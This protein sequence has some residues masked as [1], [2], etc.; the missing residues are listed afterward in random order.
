V[1]T[2][3]IMPKLGF[4]MSSGKVVRW[5]KKEGDVVAKGEPVLEIETDKATVEVQADADGL[6]GKI[7]VAEGDVP[8]GEVVG[9]IVGAGEKLSASASPVPLAKEPAVDAPAKAPQPA[10]PATAPASVAGQGAERSANMASGN[11]VHVEASPLAKRMASE[12]GIDLSAVK[13][14]GPGGRITRE[15]IEAFQATQ[16]MS[17][18][19]AVPVAAPAAPA[20]GD[21]PLSRMRQTIARRMVESKGPVPQF[22]LTTDVD[23]AAGMLVVNQLL[24]AG[25][26]EDLRPS[27][28]SLVMKACG[29]MLRKYP[30]LNASFGGDKL[31]LHDFVNISVAVAVDGGLLT[32]VVADCDRKSVAQIARD[33]R[34]AAERARS[35]KL[36]TSDL[37]QGT[38]S[39]S[40]LGMFE[41]DHFVAIVNPAEAAILALGTAKE[42]PVV[43]NGQIKSGLRMK[44]TLSADHRVTDGAE[45]ARFL[46]EVKRLLQTPMSL[47]L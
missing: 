9:E 12:M 47:F 24:E 21:K 7:L 35:G 15:D 2:K 25:K 28:L 37:A 41:I 32:P 46:Q 39:V 4:D 19:S 20:G 34:A 27:P 43:E 10:T 29:L 6:I 11:E 44:M 33:T 13:G 42:V 8:V 17:K 23:M 16:A 40:N 36:S 18:K 31:I 26:S 38:F 5:L 30:S 45:A 22:Y 3:I 14:S 1:A